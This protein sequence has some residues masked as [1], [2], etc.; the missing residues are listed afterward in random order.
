[1][2]VPAAS[3]VHEDAW[4]ETL[5]RAGEARGSLDREAPERKLRA[6]ARE[7]GIP[8]LSLVGPLRQAAGAG[9]SIFHGR[10]GHLDDGG[11]E[12]AARA[13]HRARVDGIPDQG[14]GPL[15][16]PGPGGG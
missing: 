5:A 2:E 1:V 12:V 6:I 9:A 13:I 14:L 15:L 3:Q 4:A 16:A 7:A 11:H 8:F 10:R